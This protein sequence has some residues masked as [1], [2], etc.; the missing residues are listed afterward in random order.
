MTEPIIMPRDDGP[1][2]VLGDVSLVDVEG[3]A[4]HYEGR[5]ALCRC[6]HSATKPICDAS[7]RDRG[8]DSVIRG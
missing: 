8:F 3:K 2:L 5:M 6:G 4:I 1:Y 7:H